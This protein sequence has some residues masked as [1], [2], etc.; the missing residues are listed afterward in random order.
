MNAKRRGTLKAIE[1]TLHVELEKLRDILKEE[2]TVLDNIP[3]NLWGTDRYTNCEDAIE[4][5][6]DSINSVEEAMETIS[7]VVNL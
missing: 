7:Y 2:E 1:K 3:E 6:E 4:S 5:V